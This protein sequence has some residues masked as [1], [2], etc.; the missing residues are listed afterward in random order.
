MLFKINKIV[1]KKVKSNLQVVAE[2]V[3][4][5]YFYLQVIVSSA[6]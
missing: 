1:Q 2:T 5:G 4:S 3:R 6:Q